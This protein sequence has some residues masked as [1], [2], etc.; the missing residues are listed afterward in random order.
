MTDV[1]ISISGKVG[2]GGCFLFA[3]NTEKCCKKVPL[4]DLAKIYGGE[5][6]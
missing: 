5:D 4:I 3:G 1:P 2:A 6:A